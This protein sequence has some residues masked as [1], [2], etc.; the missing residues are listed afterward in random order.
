[1]FE[2]PVRLNNCRVLDPCRD[3]VIA[4]V[5]KSKIR[6]LD[7]EIVGL[8]ATTGENDF[9]IVTTKQS[10]DLTACCLKRGLCLNRSPMP[11]DGLP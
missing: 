10:C 11:L 9:I 7:G 8:A 5:A 3:D 4:L 6:A 1:M 2:K